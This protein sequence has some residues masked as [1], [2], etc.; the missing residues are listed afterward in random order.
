MVRHFFFPSNLPRSHRGERWEQGIYWKEILSKSNWATTLL[1]KFIH[2]ESHNL[3]LYLTFSSE[4]RLS[5]DLL[6][7]CLSSTLL[8]PSTKGSKNALYYK[9]K[10]IKI[11]ASM[12]LYKDGILLLSSRLKYFEISDGYWSTAHKGLK[13]SFRF[14]RQL[15]CHQCLLRPQFIYQFHKYLFCIFYNVGCHPR[16]SKPF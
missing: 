12:V 4:S 10:T 9:K 2:H 5:K 14:C 6:Y 15:H 1:A 8:G 11:K 16:C 3:F 7:A 13:A